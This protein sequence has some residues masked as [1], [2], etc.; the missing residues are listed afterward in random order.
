MEAVQSNLGD[1][2]QWYSQNPAQLCC[3]HAA[4]APAAPTGTGIK[5]SIGVLDEEAVAERLLSELLSAVDSD[6]EPLVLSAPPEAGAAAQDAVSAATPP[7]DDTQGADGAPA[8]AATAADHADDAGEDGNECKGA[9]TSPSPPGEADESK[10]SSTDGNERPLL[11]PVSDTSRLAA[12]AAPWNAAVARYGGAV[13]REIACLRAERSASTERLAV[14]R[15]R[16]TQFLLRAAPRKQALV[17]AFQADFNAMDNDMRYQPLVKDELHM[18]TEETARALWAVISTRRVACED[19]LQALRSDSWLTDVQGSIADHY[20]ACAQLEVDRFAAGRRVVLEYFAA[21]SGRTPLVASD[22][23]EEGADHG[24]SA[25]CVDVSGLLAAPEA[26]DPKKAKKGK[27]KKKGKDEAAEEAPADPC[28]AIVD[29]VARGYKA[30]EAALKGVDALILQQNLLRQK[31]AREEAERLA[32]LNAPDDAKASKKDKKK[33][34]KKKK[35]GAA[36]EELVVP[37][38]FL[39]EALVGAPAFACIRYEAHQLRQRLAQLETLA[40]RDIEA[41][42]DRAAAV[43]DHLQERTETRFAR[44][45]AAV[46]AF[47]REARTAI[48]AEATLPLKLRLEGEYFIVSKHERVLPEAAQPQPLVVE[49]VSAAKLAPSHVATLASAL[50]SAA[51]ASSGAGAPRSSEHGRRLPRRAFIEV[52]RRLAG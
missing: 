12:A 39:P 22:G 13:E 32:A 50:R 19:E 35:G 14:T 49:H 7:A 4:Q 16:F 37:D 33:G 51:A 42:A 34:G 2:Q 28:S 25:A 48:E 27:D 11:P 31:E 9:D 5:A 40:R 6:A 21:A 41:V 29:V 15:R 26:V 43:F 18:R 38:V 46:E 20:A 47:V 45:G 10:D 1:L 23:C 8:E 30:S 36:E 17:E 52:V 44:E 3:V 24:L